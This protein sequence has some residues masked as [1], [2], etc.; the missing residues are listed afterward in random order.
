MPRP[1]PAT[2]VTKARDRHSRDVSL[3]DAQLAVVVAGVQLLVH[4]TH[5]GDAV[6]VAVGVEEPLLFAGF[7]VIGASLAVGAAREH[8]AGGGG[9]Q[10]GG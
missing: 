6:L 10:M 1:G 7:G 8:W 9:G 5:A 3:P 4:Q 2:H